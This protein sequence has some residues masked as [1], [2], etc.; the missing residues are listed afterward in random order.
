MR[1]SPASA[2]PGEPRSRRPSRTRSGRTSTASPPGEPYPPHPRHPISTVGLRTLSSDAVRR[3]RDVCSVRS[4]DGDLV[5]LKRRINTMCGV[6][7]RLRR[8]LADDFEGYQPQASRAA[9]EMLAQRFGREARLLPDLGHPSETLQRGGSRR[10]GLAED[11]VELPHGAEE[12]PLKAAA[13]ATNMLPL[14]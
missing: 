2:P 6:T 11:E 3:A 4:R 10:R 7:D 9:L 14:R 5:K 13:A 12:K 1:C 8:H